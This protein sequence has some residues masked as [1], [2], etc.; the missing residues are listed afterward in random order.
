MGNTESSTDFE[1]HIAEGSFK[2]IKQSNDPYFGGVTYMQSNRSNDVVLMKRREI[3]DLDA[4]HNMIEDLSYNTSL[5]HENFG[6]IYGFTGSDTQT[7]LKSTSYT[8]SIYFELLQNTLESILQKKRLQLAQS[9]QKI[10]IE[11]K[12]SCFFDEDELFRMMAQLVDLLEYLQQNSISHGEIRPGSCFLSLDKALKLINRRAI[13]GGDSLYEKAK[14]GPGDFFLTPSAF[15]SIGKKE[16]E[17]MQNKYK[18]DVFS[19][20][21]TLL[22]CATLKKSS[23]IYDWNNYT[24]NTNVLSARLAEVRQRYSVNFYEILKI[25]VEFDATKRPDFIVLKAL[26]SNDKKVDVTILSNHI[27]K[28]LITVHIDYKKIRKKKSFF[29]RTWY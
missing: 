5:S 1:Y 12:P 19:L 17:P 6:K 20:G 28:Y 4:Y 3:V 27:V 18:A 16:R 23:Q 14:N 8:I 21:M 11:L 22:E 25:M 9:T 13:C 24:I 2:P 15:E 26:I 7:I 10:F 29:S